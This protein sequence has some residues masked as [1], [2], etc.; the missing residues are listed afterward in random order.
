MHE[1]FVSKIQRLYDLN[2]LWVDV[3]ILPDGRVQFKTDVSKHIAYFVISCFALSHLIGFGVLKT[4]F[5]VST[6]RQLYI[7][8]EMIFEM[9]FGQQIGIQVD[10]FNFQSR[11]PSKATVLSRASRRN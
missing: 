3:F 7:Q 1:R 4:P 10:V 2:W 9:R 11:I 5:K 8:V 6:T